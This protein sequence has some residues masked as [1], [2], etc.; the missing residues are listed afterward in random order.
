M[1]A[2]IVIDGKIPDDFER[3]FTPASIQFEKAVEGFRFQQT[4][5][6]SL[7]RFLKDKVTRQKEVMDKVKTELL[8]AKDLK[9]SVI[10]LEEENKKLRQEL[11]QFQ[12]KNRPSSS[13]SNMSQRS[14]LPNPPGRLSLKPSQSQQKSPS[15]LS[16]LSSPSP[17]RQNSYVRRQ[18]SGIRVKKETYP[19]PNPHPSLGTI[20]PERRTQQD[21]RLRPDNQEPHFQSRSQSPYQFQTQKVYQPSDRPGTG[22]SLNSGVGGTSSGFG[23][24]P[25][26]SLTRQNWR[27]YSG[28]TY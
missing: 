24:L 9:R 16:L 6:N 19:Y 7:L 23:V 4:N 28:S 12:A 22:F 26:A 21:Y 13:Y 2:S 3:Y 18:G 27:D 17:S 8:A 11:S 14:N 15:A 10:Q 25:K 5:M 20:H 1:I